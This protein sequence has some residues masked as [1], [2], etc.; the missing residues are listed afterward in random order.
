MA[1]LRWQRAIEGELCRDAMRPVTRRGHCSRSHH[2]ITPR[3]Q[4]VAETG[5]WLTKM[6]W[7]FASQ[8]RRRV[9]CSAFPL[10]RMLSLKNRIA[11]SGIMPAP[12]LRSTRLW[13]F[14]K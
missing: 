13:T 9:V 6:M 1:A 8:S 14:A 4:L 10:R 11:L 3:G 7:H 12:A 5:R 2:A